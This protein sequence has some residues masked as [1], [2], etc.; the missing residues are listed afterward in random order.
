MLKTTTTML[1]MAS[2]LTVSAT[3]MAATATHRAHR[4]DARQAAAMY[5]ARYD[6][7]AQAGGVRYDP[8]TNEFQQNYVGDSL[9]ERAKGNIEG[10]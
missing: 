6:A 2:L 8:T 9:F 7:R 10:N 4:M 3:A 5:D 1:A